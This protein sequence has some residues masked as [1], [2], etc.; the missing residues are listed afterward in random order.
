V[1]RGGTWY[2]GRPGDTRFPSHVIL[3][4]LEPFA[5]A[6]LALMARAYVLHRGGAD[7]RRRPPLRR[8]LAAAARR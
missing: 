5:E 3:T 8:A 6:L 7:R 2:L 1:L 4:M